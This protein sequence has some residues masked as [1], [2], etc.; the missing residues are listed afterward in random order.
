MHFFLI[1]EKY[2]ELGIKYLH[3]L[4]RARSFVSHAKRSSKASEELRTWQN[5]RYSRTPLKATTWSR[6]PRKTRKKTMRAIQ[7]VDMLWGACNEGP[8]PEGSSGDEMELLVLHDWKVWR[9]STIFSAV[10]FTSIH[11]IVLE[12]LVLCNWKLRSYL[13]VFSLALG[14][15]CM[16]FVFFELLEL[17]NWNK[18][19]HSINSHLR[20]ILGYLR[21]ILYAIDDRDGYKYYEDLYYIYSEWNNNNA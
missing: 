10:P 9:H 5:N 11:Q 8:R 16:M 18:W 13:L 6:T 20:Y 14:L 2:L 12:L 1:R 17:W 3:W 4:Y 15:N 19:D 21:I 7:W